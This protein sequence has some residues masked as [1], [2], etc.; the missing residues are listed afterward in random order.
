MATD[1]D[2]SLTNILA[3]LGGTAN[4]AAT[5]TQAYTDLDRLST[6]DPTL[7]TADQYL[8]ALGLTGQYQYNYDD[9]LSTLNNATD[10]ARA[11]ELAELQAA[12]NAYG[13]ELAAT[14]NTAMDTLRNQYAQNIQSGINKGMQ[15]ANMLSS[16]LGTSQAGAEAAQSLADQRV[17]AALQYYSDLQKNASSAQTTATNNQQ[18]LMSN[19]RQLYND[20][21]QNRTASLEYNASLQ[22]SLANYLASQY[23]ANTNYAAT[24]NS[25]AGSV[26]AQ[27][28]YS[29]AYQAAAEEAA[30]KSYAA[31]VYAA[32]KA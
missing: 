13:R 11:V 31:T 22:E 10:A 23:T 32:D 7:M 21:I 30:Q 14:Q 3:L 24:Q 15:Q 16:I 27:N 17:Q 26:A 1:N 9:I 28:A 5:S 12:Q 4:P 18:T 2:T 25:T 29:N 6:A 19:I 8:A 20:Q